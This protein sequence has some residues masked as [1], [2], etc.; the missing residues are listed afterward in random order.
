MKEQITIQV[1]LLGFYQM[2]LGRM[3]EDVR[4]EAG[5]NLENLW[6]YFRDNYPQMQPA[7]MKRIAGMSVNGTYIQRKKWSTVTL[8]EDDKVDLLSQMAGG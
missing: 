5:A 2:M 3:Y 1:R 8:S 7:D 4:L 6:A